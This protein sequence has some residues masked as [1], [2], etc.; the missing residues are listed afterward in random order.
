VLEHVLAQ[1]HRSSL[2]VSGRGL[3]YALL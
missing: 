3:R 1:T 2:L